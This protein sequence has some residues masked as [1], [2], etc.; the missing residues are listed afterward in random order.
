MRLDEHGRWVSDDGAYIWDEA[1]QVWQPA[2][3][4]LPLTGPLQL[5]PPSATAAGSAALEVW[6]GTASGAGAGADGWPPAS[7]SG[8]LPAASSSL[9]PW[10]TGSWPVQGQD[11]GLPA[12][13]F[14]T[15][16][17]TA[18]PPGGL[19]SP[20]GGAFDTQSWPVRED[21]DP[22]AAASPAQP[23]TTGSWT[24]PPEAD[25]SPGPAVGRPD[26]LAG[27]AGA[28]SPGGLGGAGG[29][30]G[31]DDL[32]G[33]A[34]TGGWALP[35][36]GGPG[37]VSPLDTG[38]WQAQPG[39]R[40]LADPAGT[41]AYPAPD[42]AGGPPYGDH[43]Y[44]GA[45]Y[46]GPAYGGPAYGGPAYGGPAYGGGAA[47]APDAGW[48]QDGGAGGVGSAGVG[49]VGVGGGGAVGGAAPAGYPAPGAYSDGDSWTDDGG[50]DAGVAAPSATG[51]VPV[52]G[53]SRRRSRRAGRWPLA[54]TPASGRVD[55][56]DGRFDGDD[57]VADDGAVDG[58]ID[59]DDLYGSRGR[60]GR[61]G[62]L[63]RPVL[64]GLSLA[65]LA[66]LVLGA[67]LVLGGGDDD[68]GGGT[69]APAATSTR[70]ARYDDKVRRVFLE[71]CVR[72]S[73]GAAAYCTCTLE[74]LEAGYSQG[75]YLEFSDNVGDAKSQQIIR[76][77]SESC[78]AAG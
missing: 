62:S 70:G 44:G 14:G 22:P 4:S 49:G 58:R 42:A 27:L 3:S 21:P 19:A 73:E 16:A 13:A 71:E 52:D 35:P 12:E 6:Q 24:L 23:W 51:P 66:L 78:R 37:P 33:L 5:T 61:L 30:T 36:G 10:G 68:G 2:T 38:E 17:W 9:D 32:A 7:D 76:K 64:A 47:Q 40:G 34:G 11:E 25:A 1:A 75:E 28:G 54:R 77:I 50:A 46:G 29:L 55:V 45:A 26:D 53:R 65:V 15:G 67:F 72:V 8:A 48:L 56:D 39:R 31:P 18:P 43:V 59:G 41:G 60:F 74:K 63:P 20:G 57:G 69:A